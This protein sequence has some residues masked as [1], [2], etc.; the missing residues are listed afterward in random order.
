M[1]FLLSNKGIVPNQKKIQAIL[2]MTH[3]LL[4]GLGKLIRE[5]WAPNYMVY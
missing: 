1:G 5:V 4:N 2:S 3:H